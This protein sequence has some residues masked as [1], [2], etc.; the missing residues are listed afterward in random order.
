LGEEIKSINAHNKT[1]AV[2]M[3]GLP[4]GMYFYQLIPGNS[5]SIATGKFIVE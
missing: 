3:K 1:L 5:N 4:S 2:D